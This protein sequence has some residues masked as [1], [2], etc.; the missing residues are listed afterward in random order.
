MD[1]NTRYS[2]TK[3]NLRE[4]SYAIYNYKEL[5]GISPSSDL[6][7]LYSVFLHK[8]DKYKTLLK[9]IPREYITGDKDDNKTQ[10][11]T[12]LGNEGGWYYNPNTGDIRV[13][14]NKPLSSEWVTH[15]GEIPSDWIFDDSPE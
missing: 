12:R 3:Y 14:Y 2:S 9:A 10:V 6:H 5:T 1:Y 13:N 11:Y 8:N 4:L 15:E 7:E